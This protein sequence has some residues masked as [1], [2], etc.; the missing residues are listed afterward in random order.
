M[1]KFAGYQCLNCYSRWELEGEC[2]L[3][4]E[5]DIICELYNLKC[6]R[7]DLVFH[8]IHSKEEC[9]ECGMLAEECE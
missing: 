3:C 9:P 7:C 2:P 8:S 5:R 4:G 6:D 1:S